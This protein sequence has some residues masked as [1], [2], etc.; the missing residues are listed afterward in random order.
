VVVRRLSVQRHR[1]GSPVP[2][3]VCGSRSCSLVCFG[4]GAG[5]RFS[6]VTGVWVSCRDCGVVFGRRFRDPVPFNLVAPWLGVYQDLKD[7]EVITSD[8]DPE[9]DKAAIYRRFSTELDKWDKA[10]EVGAV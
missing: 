2:C 10:R 9:E 1:G 6:S 3:R 5:R 8:Y 7:D 4:G